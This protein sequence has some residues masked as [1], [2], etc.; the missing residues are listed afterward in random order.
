MITPYKANMVSPCFS[1]LRLGS[2][3]LFPVGKFSAAA[4]L[5]ARNLSNSLLDKDSSTSFPVLVELPG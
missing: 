3:S 2:F 4:A 1:L 5:S